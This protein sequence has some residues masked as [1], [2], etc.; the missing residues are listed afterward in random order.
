MSLPIATGQILE[1]IVQGNYDTTMLVE[2]VFHYHVTA[3][4]TGGDSPASCENFAAGFVHDVLPYIRNVTSSLVSYTQIV[5]NILDYTTGLLINGVPVGI[6][7]TL[8]P[9][10]IGDD[11]MPPYVCWTFKYVRADATFR[12]GFKRFAGVPELEQTKGQATSGVLSGLNTL[13]GKLQA[14]L[15]AY[16]L[17]GGVPTTLIPSAAAHPVGLQRQKSGDLLNPI[18]VQD[19]TTV[20]YDKIGTQ[21]SRKYGVGV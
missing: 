7:S 21:N 4:G 13:A 5:A 3:L 11:A 10:I 17:V 6:D 15:T 19:F 20:V 2:N 1:L 8:Q 12:H 18:N 16:T 14:Q 9:G